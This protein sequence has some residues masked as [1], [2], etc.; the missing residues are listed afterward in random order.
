LIVAGTRDG[1]FAPANDDRVAGEIARSGARVLFLGLGSPRQEIWIADQLARTGCAVGIGVG[2]SFD[3]FAGNVER[4]PEIWQ[5]LNVEWLYR[6]LREPARWRRQL[7]LPKFV[8]YVALE[9]LLPNSTR[10]FS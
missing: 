1:Y 10:R 7:A 5:R 2:G 3:V 8:F 4:A 6:L 9:R